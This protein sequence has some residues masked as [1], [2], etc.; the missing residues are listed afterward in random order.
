MAKIVSKNTP[1]KKVQTQNKNSAGAKTN[2]LIAFT[3]LLTALSA[4]KLFTP[5][6]IKTQTISCPASTPIIGGFESTDPAYT[7]MKKA[8]S[9]AMLIMV[10]IVMT[11]LFLTYSLFKPHGRKYKVF[12]LLVVVVLWVTLLGILLANSHICL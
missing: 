10:A 8:N 4:F 7:V 2:I 5:P 11:G 1:N 3:S 12:V 6:F 9:V